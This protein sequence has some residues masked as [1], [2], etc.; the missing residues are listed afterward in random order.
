MNYTILE[1]TC[2]G[3]DN[4]RKFPP[5]AMWPNWMAPAKASD[6]VFTDMRGQNRQKG[7]HIPIVSLSMRWILKFS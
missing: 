6:M 7:K 4:D 2:I 5:A 1:F 3:I